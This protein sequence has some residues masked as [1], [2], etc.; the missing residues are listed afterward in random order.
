VSRRKKTP[1]L[2]QEDWRD[3]ANGRESPEVEKLVRKYTREEA[4]AWSKENATDESVLAWV[5]KKGRTS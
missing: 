4:L 3:I 1:A 2:S 5:P